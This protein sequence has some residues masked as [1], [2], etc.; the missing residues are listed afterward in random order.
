MREGVNY[1]KQEQLGEVHALHPMRAPVFATWGQ[2]SFATMGV[3]LI[4]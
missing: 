2:L 3:Q 4:S 1:R